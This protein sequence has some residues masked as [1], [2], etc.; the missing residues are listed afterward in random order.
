MDD[1]LVVAVTA[2]PTYRVLFERSFV[3]ALK[4]KGIDATASI[5][6]IGDAMPTREKV[7][8]HL[9]DVRYVVATRYGG[10]Q[11]TKE[12]VPEQVRTYYV[13]PYYPTYSSYWDYNTIT[14]T[15]ESYVEQTTTTMLTT[16]IFD[17]R[18]EELV[19]AGRSK[20]FEMDSLNYAAEDLARQI[21]SDIKR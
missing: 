8:A 16:S 6:V 1:V 2:N 21:V 7:A 4:E 18:S 14:M 11:I 9:K 20:S 10:S 5:D 17:A 19:W 3:Q 12:V 13:G 15:R